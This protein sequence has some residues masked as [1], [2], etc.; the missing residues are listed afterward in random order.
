MVFRTEGLWLN[1]AYPTML[2][3]L[4]FV[5]ATLVHYFFAFSEKRYLKLAFQHYVPPAVVD[6]LV[7]GA[8]RLRLGG[9]KR[10]LTGVF[11]GIRGFTSVSGAVGPREVVELMKEDFTALTD[12]GF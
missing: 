1:V 3:V 8:D 7:S 10:G 2:I 4:L 12:K 11:S 5:S 6:G 9:E